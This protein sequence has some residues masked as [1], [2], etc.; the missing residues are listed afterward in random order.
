M[1][2]FM[3]NGSSPPPS[4]THPPGWDAIPPRVYLLAWTPVRSGREVQSWDACEGGL[5]FFPRG[6]GNEQ[7]RKANALGR[8]PGG[9]GNEQIRKANALG[10]WR[11]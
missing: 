4:S 5:R 3:V 7:I 1:C 9:L 10:L 6:L 11:S 8:W 2:K